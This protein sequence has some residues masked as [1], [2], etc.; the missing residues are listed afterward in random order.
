MF[1]PGQEVICINDTVDPAH[2]YHPGRFSSWIKKGEKYTIR[3]FRRPSYQDGVLLHEIRG[4]Q[5][6]HW[7]AEQLFLASRFRAVQKTD[8]SVFEKLKTPK[9]LEFA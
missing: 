7:N 5:N 3:D 8:I 6:T 2:P 9:I 1:R 4:P